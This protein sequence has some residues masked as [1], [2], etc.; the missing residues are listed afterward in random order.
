MQEAIRHHAA[1]Y[2]LWNKY[3]GIPER[4]NYRAKMPEI[5]VYPLRPEFVEST[6]TLFRATKDPFYI[7]VGRQIMCDLEVCTTQIV[8]CP[9]LFFVLYIF[10]FFYVTLLSPLSSFPSFLLLVSHLLGSS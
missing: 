4:Y 8:L 2:A 5:S 10:N 1:Y 6:Y 7:E 3:G 9:R